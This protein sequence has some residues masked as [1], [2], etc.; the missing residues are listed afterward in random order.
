[1]KQSAKA[2]KKRPPPHDSDNDDDPDYDYE[3]DRK[4]SK[5]NPNLDEY[6][7]GAGKAPC[8][9]LPTKQLKKRPPFTGATKKPHKYCPGT[10]ALCQ[11]RRYQKST[12]LL[13][14][15]LC[16]ARLIREVTQ[17]FRTEPSFPGN[18][19]VSYPRGHGGLVGQ[20][21][22]G[23]EPMCHSCQMCHHPA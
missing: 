21:H 22:G 13:C 12:E 14:R 6:Q 18:C 17:D 15:K 1:M 11:I 7:K 19:T 3:D 8:K 4:H 23:H 9:Q 10:V 5:K 16:V 20:A 2:A